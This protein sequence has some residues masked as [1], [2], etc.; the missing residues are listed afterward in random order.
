MY[1]YD[2]SLSIHFYTDTFKYEKKLIITQF[3]ISLFTILEKAN[4]DLIKLVFIEVF[5]LYDFL[6]FN[7][8]ERCYHIYKRKLC[9]LIKLVSKYDY[10]C[11]HF[12]NKAVIHI[13]YKFLVRFLWTNFYE[14]IYDHWINKLK[15]LN[16][17]I[18]HISRRRNRIV[19]D[20]FKTLFLN[21]NCY[22]DKNVKRTLTA[23]IKKGPFWVWKDEKDKYEKFLNNLNLA[24]KNEIIEHDTLLKEDVFRILSAKIKTNDS[25][26]TAY[27]TFE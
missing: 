14:D 13:D 12:R 21:E 22:P 1:D 24:Q 10:F 5:I 15:R 7:S 3:Q 27:L 16:L 26:K 20:L 8:F 11:K 19:D 18:V 2:Y 25:W 4:H 9:A 6:I 23:L 17:E